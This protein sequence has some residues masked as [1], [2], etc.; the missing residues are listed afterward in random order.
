M[1]DVVEREGPFGDIRRS[2]LF[3]LL[4][5][6]WAAVLLPNNTKKS[7]SVKERRS[8][9]FFDRDSIQEVL[10]NWR[11]RRPTRKNQTG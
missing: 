7:V 3:I 8:H 4:M 9:S 1:V 5:I 2:T 11:S 10:P 6:E